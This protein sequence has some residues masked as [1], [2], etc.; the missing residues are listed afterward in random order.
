MGMLK[1]IGE[2]VSKEVAGDIL[3]GV[4]DKIE[5]TIENTQ[6]RVEQVT[7]HVIKSLTLLLMFFIGLIFIL[8]G[9]SQYLE[10][11]FV[12]ISQGMGLLYVG[13]IMVILAVIVKALK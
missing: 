8:V 3:G 13:G 10:E 6:E 2:F 4:K 1:W 9:F 12:S 11:R 7:K 5:E